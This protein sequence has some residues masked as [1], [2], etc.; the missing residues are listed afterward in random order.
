VSAFEIA[1][2]AEGSAW[3]VAVRARWPTLLALA[4]AGLT[5]GGSPM[6]GLSEALLLFGF[7]YLA[8]AVIQRRRLTWLIACSAVL[9]LALLRLQ[10]RVDPAVV[11]IVAAVALVVWGAVRGRLLPPGELLTEA[12][13]MAFF[14]A[15]GL[16]ALMVEPD[17][18]RYLLAAG[19]ISHALWDIAH[20][21]AN[22]VVSRSFVEWCAVFDF[23]GG[24]SILIFPA[25]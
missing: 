4:I 19:W 23:I 20:W 9:A 2:R 24:V 8:A 16:A 1:G 12:G 6:K 14:A 17:V 7:G 13:G 22:R 15:V 11:L 18:G 3:W 10:D 25:I 21:R 5:W